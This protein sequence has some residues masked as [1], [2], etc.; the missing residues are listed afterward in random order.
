MTRDLATIANTL[1][2]AAMSATATAQF[3]D[4]APLSAEQAYDVQARLLDLHYQRGARRVGVKMGLTSKAKMEQ[5]GVD[6]VIWGRL[7]DQMQAKDGG[8]FERARFIHPRVEPEIAFIMAAP[9]S[10]EVS[11]EEA[12]AAVD[13]VAPALEI[14]DSRYQ[15]FRFNLGDVIADNASSAGFVI[16]T[17]CPADRPLSD[18][19][20]SM[21]IGDRMTETGS[22]NAILGHP[23]NALVAASRMV[24]TAGETLR[25]GDIVLAGAATA[26]VPVQ[27]GQ[28][29]R[30]EVEGL[31]TAS[32]SMT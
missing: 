3:S 13:S 27:A 28:S 22:S 20:M 7:T 26:A 12:I 16:G 29:V 15:D 21:F 19:N 1:D 24:A 11:P 17:P 10:G 5:V 14:I 4:T 25:P 2:Q 23:V 30:L 6:D 18:L 8:S 9:L 31:G 32:L